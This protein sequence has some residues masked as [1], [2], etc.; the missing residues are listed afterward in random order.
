MPAG[1]SLEAADFFNKLI[2]RK[3]INRLGLN[4]PA[5]VKEHTWFKSYDWTALKEKKIPSPFIPPVGDNF[6]EKYTNGDWKD[7]NEEAMRQHSA[8]LKRASVQKCFDGYYYDEKLAGQIED[9]LP[10]KESEPS[11]LSSSTK[12]NGPSSGQQSGN[13]SFSKESA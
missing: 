2:Q 7:N 3:P 10:V 13:Q 12:A 9:K 4:G 5:E 11:Q 6:D 8:Q 1:W